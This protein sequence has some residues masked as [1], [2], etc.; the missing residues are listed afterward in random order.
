[1]YLTWRW[2]E[3]RR[4]H[5]GIT[6]SCHILWTCLDE[7]MSV[8]PESIIKEADRRADVFYA[9][10]KGAS[11]NFVAFAV[12]PLILLWCILTVRPLPRT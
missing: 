9:S 10:T 11:L 8:I 3:T 5:L 1:M 6:G 2:A 7:G 12:H 4:L